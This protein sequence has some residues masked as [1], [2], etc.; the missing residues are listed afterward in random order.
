MVLSPLVSRPPRRPLWRAE[1]RRAPKV[2]EPVL[3]LHVGALAGEL[4]ALRVPA[5]VQLASGIGAEYRKANPTD[6][7]VEAIDGVVKTNRDVDQL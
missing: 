6:P 2:R 7:V 4:K 3:T 1:V 5:D